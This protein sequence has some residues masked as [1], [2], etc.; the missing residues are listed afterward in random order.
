ME[1]ILLAAPRFAI[2]KKKRLEELG[3]AERRSFMYFILLFIF[4][5]SI[6][7]N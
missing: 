4:P 6:C 3:V 2:P 1:Q 7:Y 5:E